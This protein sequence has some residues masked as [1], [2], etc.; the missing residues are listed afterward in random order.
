MADPRLIIYHHTAG[1]EVRR[2]S[3][4]EELW[5]LIDTARESDW[6]LPYNFVVMPSPPYRIYYINDVDRCWPHTYDRNCD[7]AIAAFGNFSVDQPAVGLAP[8]MMALADALAT[9]WGEWVRESQH[10]DWSAT[11]CPGTLLSPLLP[12]AD[13]QRDA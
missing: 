8:R 7:T 2:R 1:G 11:E 3:I 12:S 4:R 10:R 9:M 5:A 13:R 6:G